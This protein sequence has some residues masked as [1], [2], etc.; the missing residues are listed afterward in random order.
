MRSISVS[1]TSAVVGCVCG[2][3][4]G[5][6]IFHDTFE[7]GPSPL[8]RNEIGSWSAAGGE[9]FAQEPSNSPPTRTTL[10][11]VLGDFDFSV[12]VRDMNDGGIW[13]RIDDA[14]T[15]G[16]LLVMGG[17]GHSYPGFYWHVISGGGYS[18][19]LNFSAPI[20]PF[21]SDARVRVQVRGERY[22]VYLDDAASPA[23][24]LDSGVVMT[25]HVGLYD[26]TGGAL[27]FDNV[28]L[29][30]PCAAD[31][32][33]DSVVNSQDFFDFLAAFFG[34]A[35]AA[36]FNHDTFVN[37]QDFFDFLAAFFGGC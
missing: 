1:V 25:G 32:N 4:A 21:G 2:A 5:Q 24:S 27:R 6:T 15:N 31:F 30:V 34:Q 33:G 3:A 12:D 20:F 17:S 14:G 29:T 35:P 9:Y 13:L 16:V 11:F 36:D 37:S 23:T 19:P 10:P 28:V 18:A 22:E 7:Q 26:F 8:W